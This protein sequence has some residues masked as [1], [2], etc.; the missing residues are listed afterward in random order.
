V[1]LDVDASDRGALP[2]HDAAWLPDGKMLLALGEAG[3]RLVTRDGRTA[4]HFDV[5]AHWLVMF[6]TGSAALLLAPRGNVW[7]V[8]RLDLLQRRSEPLGQLSL[9]MF[10]DTTDGALWLVTED[11]AVVALDLSSPTLRALWRVNVPHVHS[12]AR[13]AISLSML[14]TADDRPEW[15]RYELPSFTLRVRQELAPQPHPALV[16]ASGHITSFDLNDHAPMNVVQ[17]TARR[18]TGV[19]AGRIYVD[20]VSDDWTSVRSYEETRLSWQLAHWG[21]QT[22][23]WVARFQRSPNAGHTRLRNDVATWSDADGRVLAVDLLTGRLLRN[24]RVR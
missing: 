10:T 20:A 6:D 8:S 12:I 18:I 1:Q 13:N 7:T 24:L 22:V 3:A 4:A 17:S 19:A 15:W 5:P 2:V 9:A 11:G 21:T 23:R 16:T 14:V